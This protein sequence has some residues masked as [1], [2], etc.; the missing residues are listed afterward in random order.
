MA[1]LAA[2]AGNVLR[3]EHRCR[4]VRY[5]NCLSAMLHHSMTEWIL[6][7]L[8][9]DGDYPIRQ[10]SQ[11]AAILGDSIDCANHVACRDDTHGKCVLDD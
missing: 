5:L 2:T 9:L 8:D 10:H 4:L 6:G 11:M 3:S 7:R 1:A